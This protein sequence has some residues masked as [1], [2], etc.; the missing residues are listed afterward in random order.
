LVKRLNFFMGAFGAT[1]GMQALYLLISDPIPL[2]QSMLIDAALLTIFW[3]LA[4]S[5]PQ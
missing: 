1:L 5:C 2:V 3:I 4:R